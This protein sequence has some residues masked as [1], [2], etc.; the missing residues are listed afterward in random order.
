[1]S[2]EPVARMID[3]A[4][5][6]QGEALPRD[7]RRELAAAIDQALPWWAALEGAGVHRLNVAAGGGPQALLSN[8]TRLTLRVP[9]ERAADAAA[10]QGATLQ[11][12]PARLRIGAPQP[13]ELRPYSTLY[14]HLVAA[15]EDEAAFLGAV[16]DELSALG[17]P[18]R[19]ICGRRQVVEA[20]A[21][22]GYSLMLDGLN[23]VGALRVLEVGIGRH[24]RWGC[25]VFVPHKSAVAVGT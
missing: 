9:R 21:L 1:M 19:P 2:D 22:Q 15:D 23:P 7:H 6:L 18:C 17:V 3:L 20:G 25:G 12:G 13:R 10:L 14:A 4:F 5:V 8:R 24:R 16:A 11:V